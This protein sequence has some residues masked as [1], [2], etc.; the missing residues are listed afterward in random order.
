MSPRLSIIRLSHSQ[1]NDRAAFPKV[2]SLL[3][4]H[5]PT[6]AYHHRSLQLQFQFRFRLR[7]RFRFISFRYIFVLLFN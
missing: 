3:E 2:L 7:F 6:S 5:Q 1:S 4:T